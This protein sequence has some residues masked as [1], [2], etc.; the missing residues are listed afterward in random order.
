[1]TLKEIRREAAET[2]ARIFPSVTASDDRAAWKKAL[3][4]SFAHH[5]RLEATTRGYPMFV[6]KEVINQLSDAFGRKFI[7]QND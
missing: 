7:N 5:N 1:M 4:F 2:V 6:W 3:Q